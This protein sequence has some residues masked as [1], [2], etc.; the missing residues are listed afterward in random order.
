M[1]SEH[2]TCSKCGSD[3]LVKN[4][5]NAVGNAKYLCK[6]CGFSGVI[7]SRRPSP[8]LKEALLRASN[9]RT[10]LRSLARIFGVSH[11]TASNWIKK[12]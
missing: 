3:Q 7:H 8:A 11:Q 4:G 12:S 6:T 10:S 9:E 5:K 2:K 1:I